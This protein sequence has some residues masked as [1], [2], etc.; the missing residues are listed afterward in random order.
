MVTA[1]HQPGVLQVALGRGEIGSGEVHTPDLAGAPGEQRRAEG[2]RVCKEV[3]EPTPAGERTQPA[4]VV[5]LVEE[6]ADARTR[7]IRP[8]EPQ[9]EGEA[10]PRLA[11]PPWRLGIASDR[12]TP[13]DPADTQ[14]PRSLGTASQPDLQLRQPRRQSPTSP[15]PED[16]RHGS[17]QPHP[18]PSAERDP[19]QRAQP[20]HREPG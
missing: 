15:L 18:R 20:V 17:D 6:E 12:R 5:A 9:V 14:Q 3:D 10:Q 4:A 7:P 2:P 8:L 1:P 13:G 11:H 19:Q 16:A